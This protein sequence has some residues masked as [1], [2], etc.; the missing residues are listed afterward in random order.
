M[1][2]LAFD[3]L[4]MFYMALCSIVHVVLDSFLTLIVARIAVMYMNV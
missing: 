4:S 2:L 3:V 1:H